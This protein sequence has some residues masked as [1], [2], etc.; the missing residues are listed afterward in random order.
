METNLT[1]LKQKIL[2]LKSRLI[3][4]AQNVVS[5]YWQFH[6]YSLK[7]AGTAECGE[8]REKKGEGEER[9]S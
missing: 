1:M 2:V 3:K 4:F 9:D 8:E 5:A 7:D 6:T